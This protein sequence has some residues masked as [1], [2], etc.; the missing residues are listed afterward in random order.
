MCSHFS[1]C[2]FYHLFVWGFFCVRFVKSN[3]VIPPSLPFSPQ[4]LN[5]FFSCIGHSCK[6]CFWKCSYFWVRRGNG[7]YTSETVEEGMFMWLTIS[8]KIL[9]F[10]GCLK[11]WWKKDTAKIILTKLGKTVRSR[12]GFWLYF[13]LEN[14]TS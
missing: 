11:R 9:H 1:T 6:P 5:N 13:L 10:V 8:K 3:K 12:H 2:L 14:E 7:H 4:K